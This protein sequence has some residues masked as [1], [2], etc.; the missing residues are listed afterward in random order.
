MRKTIEYI[1]KV[2]ARLMLWRYKPEVIAIT[3]SVGKTGTREAIYRVL[4]KDFSVRR[5]IRNYNNEVGVP[6]TILGSDEAP[7]TRL[8]GVFGWLFIF[9]KAL[10]RL[11][12]CRYPEIL[13]LEMG[14]AKPDDMAYLLSFIPVDVGVITAIGEFPSHLEFF[15][16]KDALVGEKA[17]LVKSLGKKGLAVLNYDDLSVRS[18][19]H[20]LVC[21]KIS[22]GFGEGADV[23]IEN[24]EMRVDGLMT[25]FKLV[26][27]GS[28]VPVKLE[29]LGK[30]K[31]FAVAAAAAVGLHYG[32][33]LIQISS[34]LLKYRS[35]PG[36]TNL[37][38]GIKKTLIID[39]TYNASPLSVLAALDILEKFPSR[40]IAVL[41]DMLELGVKT[42]EA[43]RQIGREVNV[44]ILLT[45]GARAKFIA[46]E[47][48]KRGIKTLEFD[49]A[50][51]VRIQD[52]LEEGDTIL[53]KGSR[54]MHLEKVVEDIML[55][56]E[57]A[58]KLLVH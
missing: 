6:L 24:Y 47:A 36:R 40:K 22:Y 2:L 37:L 32:L 51:E 53:V 31:A 43:H 57:K 29:L 44:D 34:A 11:V 18:L 16:E 33:N 48:K 56:P 10:F 55:H 5:S 23:R 50:D 19:G 8:I 28:V 20:D 21:K 46:D 25:T 15:P 39:D 1:L 41:G 7:S 4:K 49:V 35:M 9:I 14:I 3:G 13:I 26:H 38:K 30:Q 17:L 58:K 27:G 42:E 12:W 45:V 52:L 54:A